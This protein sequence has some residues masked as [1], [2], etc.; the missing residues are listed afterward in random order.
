MGRH[1]ARL[2]QK[3]ALLG[4]IVDI[5]AELFAIASACTYARTRGSADPG[6]A[7]AAFELADMFCTQARRRADQLFHEPWST[8]DDNAQYKFAG[9]VLG[10]RYTFF[11]VAVVDPAGAE[12]TVLHERPLAN[13]RA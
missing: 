8:N 9:G 2:E 1:Q 3:G 13:P 10:G 5:G 6:D 4:R 12:R 7:E 11:E